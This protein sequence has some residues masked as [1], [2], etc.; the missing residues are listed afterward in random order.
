MLSAFPVSS[1]E[2]SCATLSLKCHYLHLWVTKLSH[3][4]VNNLPQ[5]TRLGSD[6]QIQTSECDL[7]NFVTTISQGSNTGPP[8]FLSTAPLQLLLL[9]GVRLVVALR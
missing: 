5:V 4:I 6:A 9:E 7:K 3:G 8:C 1:Q 2:T